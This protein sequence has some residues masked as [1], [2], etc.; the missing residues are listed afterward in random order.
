MRMCEELWPGS[1]AGALFQYAK[2]TGHSGGGTG[3]KQPVST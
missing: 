3:R 1:S 2:V